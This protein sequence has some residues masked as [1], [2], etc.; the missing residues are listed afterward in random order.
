MP[1]LAPFTAGQALLAG[2]RV[3]DLLSGHHAEQA[4]H[5]RAGHNR[6]PGISTDR[7]RAKPPGNSNAAIPVNLTGVVLCS[8]AAG[9]RTTP[10][11]DIASRAWLD[12]WRQTAYSWAH[13]G[14]ASATENFANS[15]EPWQSHFGPLAFSGPGTRQAQTPRPVSVERFDDKAAGDGRQAE[16]AEVGGR[17]EPSKEGRRASRRTAQARPRAFAPS[18]CQVQLAGWWICH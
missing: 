3:R 6:D 2:G 7:A 4:L 13:G 11:R 9:L 17:Q 18:C 10:E 1:D 8:Q 15:A 5:R 16:R 12:W 14:V